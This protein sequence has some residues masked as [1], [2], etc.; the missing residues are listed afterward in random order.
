MRNIGFIFVMLALASCVHIPE[1]SE[2]TQEQK[3]EDQS[4]ERPSLQEIEWALKFEEKVKYEN[5]Q[6]HP[7]ELAQYQ[8]LLR[9]LVLWE[10][11][12]RT[13]SKK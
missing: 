9:R 12:D 5:Y 8:D 7:E 2:K 10:K 13:K 3:Q 1:G 11:I 6:P 4:D